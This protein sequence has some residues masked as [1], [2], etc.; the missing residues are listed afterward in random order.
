MLSEQ[1]F[2]RRN[3][4]SVSRAAGEDDDEGWRT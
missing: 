1:G 2:V 4:W 3:D